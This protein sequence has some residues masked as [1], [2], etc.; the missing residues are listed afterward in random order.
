MSTDCTIFSGYIYSYEVHNN[1]DQILFDNKFRNNWLQYF[2]MLLTQETCSLLQIEYHRSLVKRSATD[3]G[4][5]Q[6]RLVSN[7]IQIKN[8]QL[9]IENEIRFWLFSYSR[10]HLNIVGWSVL[11]WN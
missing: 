10:L 2:L 4:I 1:G 11:H 9:N 8:T 6:N 7:W 3:K 5:F